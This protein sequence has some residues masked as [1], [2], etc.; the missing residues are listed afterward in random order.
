MNAINLKITAAKGQRVL[1]GRDHYWSLMMDAEM[2]SEPFSID[3][4]F[5]LS[6]NRS[7]VQIASFVADLERARIIQPTGDVNGRGMAFYRVA[8]RQSATPVFSRAGELIAEPM[9]ARQA[10][11]NGM[12]SPFFRAGFSIVDLA[13]FAS[14]DALKINPRSA[15]NY[16]LRLEHAGYLLALREPGM[17]TIW[18]LL[19]NTGPDAPKLIH[20]ECIYDPNR[21]AVVGQPK[22]REVQP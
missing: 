9:T 19:V 17:H 10:L 12:R 8:I 14:T 18:R 6:N 21:N 2:R 22:T 7:R 3:D 5:G 1:T 15:K 20:A 11:W 13:A 16:V 4:I